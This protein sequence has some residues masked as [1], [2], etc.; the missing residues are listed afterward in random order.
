MVSDLVALVRRAARK[1][2]RY[3]AE[4]LLQEGRRIGDRWLGPA[5]RRAMT[6][7]R[8]LRLLG[9]ETT[10]E[11]WGA[12]MARPY[13]FLSVE[14][15]AGELEAL[16]PGEMARILD[17][18]KAALAHRVDLLG[19]GP[20]EL[21]PAID[22]HQDF[23]TGRRWPPAY[24]HA[25]EYAN[26]D[27][28]SDV[29]LPWELSRLQWLLPAAQAYVLT[30]EARYAEC[31]REVLEQWIDGNP[32]AGSV[33]WSCTMEAALRIVTL[34]W[35]LRACGDSL[36]FAD[37]GFRVKVLGSLLLHAD[38]TDRYIERSDVNGN[39]YTADAAGLVFAG[40]F[41]GD[42]PAASGWLETGWRI[43]S[44]EIARQVFP[45]GVD[46]EASV[47]YHRLVTELFLLP[48]LYAQALG[49]EVPARWR[50]RLVAMSRFTAA[51]SRNDGGVPIWG[52]NDDA[53]MLPMAG[54][55][56]F[57][58]RYLIGLTAFGLAVEELQGLAWG[59]VA[60]L[61]WLLGPSAARNAAFQTRSARSS[62]AFPDGGFYILASGDDHV[63]I[64]CGPIGLAGRGG[65]GHNDLMSFEAALR[66][67]RLIV[68]PGSYVYTAS[69]E[70]RNAFRS[71]AAH[72][73]PQVASSEINRFVSPRH[74]WSL[75]NDATPRVLGWHPG[76]RTST[77][78]M[79]HDG[80]ARL[81]PTV[82]LIR[83]IQLDHET[84]VLVVEDDLWLRGHAATVAMHIAPEVKVRGTPATGYL[85]L[86]SGE[87]S[88]RLIWEGL[89]PWDATLE[90]ALVAPSYGCL[91]RTRKVVWRVAG[92]ERASLQVA[93]APCD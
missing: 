76:D 60:E 88:F 42:G 14:L 74:L 41:L 38:F 69:P 46:Y 7:A 10:D 77:I 3:I 52:D 75:I 48:A 15:T 39:H 23:K 56:L 64:D 78:V 37:R 93:I 20:I 29:K 85:I 4:R 30:G 61:A 19:S 22:W 90:T 89:G 51:Y 55:G 73:T 34:T 47:P 28:P 71:T 31:V 18:A 82:E 32:Y 2:P 21:G 44:E 70:M 8:V 81:S 67:K 62:E 66:G 43:L 65:H 35:L 92:V 58:H 80:Y 13:P 11:A 16:A 57:D 27:E 87:S 49:R 9:F 83:R 5:R 72:N 53:R 25:I 33:N 36:A 86:A 17:E 50:D 6:E 59:P 40:L 79:S 45:D 54:K 12:L 68:D 91:E 84:G 63:F 26:L 1:P 24:C